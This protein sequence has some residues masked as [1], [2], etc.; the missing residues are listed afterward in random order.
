MFFLNRLRKV[1]L[2]LLLSLALTLAFG[3]VLTQSQASLANRVI[4]LHVLANSDRPEDQA[5][6]LKVRDKILKEAETVLGNEG[7]LQE[8]EARLREDL[9]SLAKAGADEVAAEGYH[10]TVTVRLE[11]TYFP[12]KEY[13]GF[14]FPA[15]E[16]TALRVL[17]GKGEGHNWWC[18]LFPPLCQGAVTEPVEQTAR[19]AGLSEQQVS[20]ITEK[21]QGYVL[22][23]KCVELWDSFAH[24]L[25]DHKK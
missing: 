10:D 15:G 23:F 12:T 22:K 21:N 2:A 6:K 7:N 9:P 19:K 25:E 3:S 16:Y 24:L 13:D 11:K 14:S 17:I 8:A 18:V 4:R 5:L 20:L 1:E